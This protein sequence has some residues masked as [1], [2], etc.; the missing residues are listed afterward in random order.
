LFDIACLKINADSVCVEM[1]RLKIGTLIS[2]LMF[3]RYRGQVRQVNPVRNL[4]N[5]LEH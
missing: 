2:I 4:G 1:F 3:S 5:F